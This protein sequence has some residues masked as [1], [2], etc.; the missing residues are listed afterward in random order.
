MPKISPRMIIYAVIVIGLVI[1]MFTLCSPNIEEKEST[2]SEIIELFQNKGGYI[3]ITEDSLE[4]HIDGKKYIADKPDGFNPTV[5][6][7]LEIG[8]EKQLEMA[9]SDVSESGGGGWMTTILNFMPLLLIGVLF[10]LIMRRMGKRNE[11]S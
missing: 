9:Y 6:L 10:F 2:S 4:A 7:P 11:T 1:A 3:K 5:L 8:S